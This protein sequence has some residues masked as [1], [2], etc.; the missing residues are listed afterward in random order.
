MTD[1]TNKIGRRT[2]AK[3][4]AWSVPVVALGAG[5]AQ[6]AASPPVCPTNCAQPVVSA[7]TLSTGLGNPATGSNR[8]A[9]SLTAGAFYANFLACDGGGLFQASI[10]TVTSATLTMSDGSTYTTTSGLPVGVAAAS[11]SALATVGLSFQNVFFP[12]GNL[13]SGV[14]NPPVRPSRICFTYTVVLNVLG[15]V[16]PATK[17]CNGQVC[18]SFNLL[19]GSVYTVNQSVLGVPVPNSVSYVTTGLGA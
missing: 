19:T 4:A 18:F 17:D 13:L 8:A 15:S 6:A 9:L 3:G 10:F 2:I 16:P 12:N 11:Q 5:A 1:E 7:A 14:L